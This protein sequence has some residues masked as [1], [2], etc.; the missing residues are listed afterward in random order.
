MHQQI[1]LDK[2]ATIESGRTIEGNKNLESGMSNN[3]A[4]IQDC[5]HH[6]AIQYLISRGSCGTGFYCVVAIRLNKYC[7]AFGCNFG[8]ARYLLLVQKACKNIKTPK[9]TRK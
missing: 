5:R 7:A 8:P 3:K 2:K 6:T 4:L 9:S 1:Q